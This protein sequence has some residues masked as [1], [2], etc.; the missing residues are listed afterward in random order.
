MPETNQNIIQLFTIADLPEQSRIFMLRI[1]GT[2]VGTCTGTIHNLYQERQQTFIGLADAVLKMDAMMDDLGSPQA[3]QE[4]RKF[5]RPGQTSRK[6]GARQQ[7]RRRQRTQE[8][9]KMVCQYWPSASFQ[10][11]DDNVMV[12]FVRVRFRQHSSWQGDINW[13]NDGQKVQ[14]R[15]VLEL[16]HLLQSALE[17]QHTAQAQDL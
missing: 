15:S 2:S 10:S 12:F 9:P 3:T 14:F 6:G 16:L 11:E 5:A 17:S 4:S 1:T 7:D 8:G 13:R